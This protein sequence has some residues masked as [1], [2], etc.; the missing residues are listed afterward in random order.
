MSLSLVAKSC[1]LG[2]YTCHT[3]VGSYMLTLDFIIRTSHLCLQVVTVIL[4]PNNILNEFW[5]LAVCFGARAQ[6]LSFMNNYK[7]LAS[8]MGIR[9]ITSHQERR[10][11][12]NY[13]T[14]RPQG[15]WT[16]RSLHHPNLPERVSCEHGKLPRDSFWCTP[17]SFP[18]TLGS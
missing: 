15:C 3:G 12:F 2:C 6:S 14:T 4:S 1:M 16:Q 11:S 5:S 9:W 7:H 17:D 10:S 8:S 13:E 18:P